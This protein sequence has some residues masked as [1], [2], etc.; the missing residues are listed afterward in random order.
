MMK[1]TLHPSIAA[2][3]SIAHNSELCQQSQ[4]LKPWLQL[5]L[6]FTIILVGFYWTST[7]ARASELTFTDTVPLTYTP[8]VQVLSVPQFNPTAG[9]LQ[10][11]NVSF[12]ARLRGEGYYENRA[13]VTSTISFE[14]TGEVLFG[15]D[16]GDDIDSMTNIAESSLDVPEYDGVGGYSAAGPLPEDDEE[17]LKALFNGTSGG[18][19]IAESSKSF[20]K[21]YTDSVSLERFLGSNEVGIEV[22]ADAESSANDT[23]GNVD[24]ELRSLVDAGMHITYTYLT[25]DIQLEKTVYLGHDNGASCPGVE[26]VEDTQDNPITYCFKVTNTGETY[27]NNIVISDT[28]LGI[29]EKQMTL[30][31]GTEP[32]AP[33]AS[34]IFY[35]EQ[36]LDRQFINTA[37]VEGTPT[38]VT[39]RAVQGLPNPTDSDIAQVTFSP[40]ALE[41]SEEPQPN[42]RLFLPLVIH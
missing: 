23:T 34:M 16:T 21:V 32:L 10:S 39:G 33:Q 15:F 40:K 36:I 5:Y 30:I 17:R 35:V 6:A 9:A 41:E 26:K 42:Q 24:Y 29:S 28:N 11:V 18:V 22:L 1:T 25:T 19:S 4:P 13:S 20:N 37:T 7:P 38:D 27:L 31:S 14:H 3:I 2:P 12:Q 8:W